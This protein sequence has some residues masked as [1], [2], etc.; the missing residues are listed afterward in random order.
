V[1]TEG[2]HDVVVVGGGA[3]GLSAALVLGRA[4]RSVVVVDAGSPRN[5]PSPHMHG[6]LSRDGMPPRDLLAKGRAELAKYDVEM[7]EDRVISI[8]AGFFARL[9]GGCVLTARRVLVATGVG[10]DLPQIAGARERWGR[11]L[12][13]CPYCHGW[14]VR[15]QPVGVVGDRPAAVDHAQLVRQWSDDVIY[16]ADEYRP[17]RAERRALEARGIE[18]VEGE[19]SR[20]IV[21][22]DR[23][24]GVEL[25]DGRSFAR[26]AIFIRPRNKPHQDGLLAGLGCELD[27][28]GF[29]R[30]DS[31]GRTSA[32][33][34]WAA[35]NA[36]DPR[37][38]V[39]SAAG[40][41]AAAAIAMNADLLEEDIA[42]ALEAREQ[43][44]LA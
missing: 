20:L 13:H 11:D 4:R 37:V 17:A 14:E 31:D 40:A 30:V 2:I 38:P 35:G 42:T 29:V 12:L 41:G 23:L 32:A 3:A 44:P 28:G 1:K 9:S 15:D 5:A 10:D 19:L 18:V 43:E 26:S 33:G 7:I 21:E 27:E 24:T 36:A 39:I 8:Q 34:V 25:V 22:N 6:Y 16:F